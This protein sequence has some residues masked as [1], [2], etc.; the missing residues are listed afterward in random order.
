MYLSVYIN[1][2]SLDIYVHA[3]RY[4]HEVSVFRSESML[5]PEKS[6]CVRIVNYKRDF[7]HSS[8]SG[9]VSTLCFQL[10]R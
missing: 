5:K 2:N 4:D 10:P 9:V 1:S 7:A 8:V 6:S 3:S